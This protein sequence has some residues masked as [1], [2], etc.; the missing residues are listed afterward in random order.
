MYNMIVIKINN[1]LIFQSSEIM[2]YV[3]YKVYQDYILFDN[4]DLHYK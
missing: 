1:M 2:F 4:K 3:K